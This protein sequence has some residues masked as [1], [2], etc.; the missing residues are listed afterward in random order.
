MC[1][2]SGVSRSGGCGS[3]CIVAVW[4]YFIERGVGSLG[5]FTASGALHSTCRCDTVMKYAN[6][7]A[8]GGTLIFMFLRQIHR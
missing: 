3:T 5:H 4:G 6:K 7:D 8:A 1:D 2:F